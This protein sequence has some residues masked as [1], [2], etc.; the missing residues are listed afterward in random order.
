V[1]G[2]AWLFLGAASAFAV[3]NWIAVER[4]IRSLE[5]ACKPA[6]LASLI[7]VA[8]TLEP[9]DE[10]VRWLFVAALVF[11]L[12]GDV[13][14]MLQ[15]EQFQAGVGSFALAHL[16]YAAGFVVDGVTAL[17]LAVGVLV[18]VAGWFVF[19]RRIIA[20][21]KQQ[22]PADAGPVMAYVVIIS[23]MVIT[24]IGVGE[25]V[26]IAGALSFYASDACIAWS[27]F[28]KEFPHFRITIMVTYHVGQAL[29]VLS[30][31]Q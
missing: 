31:L 11:S 26:A 4:G 2:V 20:A 28:I 3:G 14:L 16:L 7:V 1:T 30:L 19:G 9:Q 8:A 23:L 17:G 25:P 13:F 12:A 27:R 22:S 6:T 24:A 29:L 21:V 18:V 10:A 15:K 5:V